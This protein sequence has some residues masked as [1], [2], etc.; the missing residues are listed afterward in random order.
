MGS[1]VLVGR[2]YLT[3]DLGWTKTR[4]AVC[5]MAT[6]VLDFAATQA[7]HSPHHDV[8]IVASLER[9]SPL[10]D[11]TPPLPSRCSAAVRRLP[12]S[13]IGDAAAPTTFEPPRSP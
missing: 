7:P 9:F 11:I 6:V 3:G 12:P 5:P 8:V 1:L 2:C 10:A 13:P 4:N